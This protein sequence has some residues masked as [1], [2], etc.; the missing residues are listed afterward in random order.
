MHA[1]APAVE[2]AVK[3]S[4]NWADQLMLYAW[5]PL[6]GM[7]SDLSYVL[8]ADDVGRVGA[9]SNGPN[10]FLRLRAW[11]TSLDQHTHLIG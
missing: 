6:T 9:C 8:Y 1:F 10:A 4:Q 3:A 7:V 2:R 5:D 11:D